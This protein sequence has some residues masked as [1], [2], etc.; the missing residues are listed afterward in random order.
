MYTVRLPIDQY[1]Y[2]IL[3]FELSI[4]FT[5][6]LSTINIKLLNYKPP[7]Q[8]LF[9]PNT[10]F[11]YNSNV[12]LLIINYHLIFMAYYIIPILFIRI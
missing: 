5:L 1:Y 8:T 4:D 6:Y 9:I 11:Y 12:R 2:I 10:I 7:C 3:S